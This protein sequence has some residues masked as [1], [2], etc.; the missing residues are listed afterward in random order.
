MSPYKDI[1]VSLRYL[2]KRIKEKKAQRKGSRDGFVLGLWESSRDFRLRHIAYCE[3]RGKSRKQIEQPGESN[4][5]TDREE[6]LILSYRGSLRTLVLEQ[7]RAYEAL[8]SSKV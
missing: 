2:A 6:A 8:C 7:E 4:L 1:R 3:S 5:L